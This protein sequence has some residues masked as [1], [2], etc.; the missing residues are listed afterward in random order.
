[1]RNISYVDFTFTLS[2]SLSDQFCYENNLE[3]LRPT[4]SEWYYAAQVESDA[5]MQKLQAA[6]DAMVAAGG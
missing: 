5:H 6:V 1:M 4:V 2:K 3:R